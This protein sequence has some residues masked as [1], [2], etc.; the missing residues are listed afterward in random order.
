MLG[1]AAFSG[2][3]FLGL[4]R[5]LAWRGLAVAAFGVV[6]AGWV[7]WAVAFVAGDPVA[8]WRGLGWVALFAVAVLALRLERTHPLRPPAFVGAVWLAAATLA[9]TLAL[10][11]D[12]VAGPAWVGGS[13]GAVFAVGLLLSVQVPTPAASARARAWAVGGLLVAAVL[14]TVASW[15]SDGAADPLPTL[16][17]LNPLGLPTVAVLLGVVAARRALPDRTP[18]LAVLVGALGFGALTVEVLRGAHA[19]GAAPWTAD[20]LYAS[21]TAQAALAVTWTVLALALAVVA[22]RR[23]SRGLWFFGAGV[24]AAVVLKLFLVDLSQAEALVRIGA[25]IAVGA[26]G[27]LIGYQAPLPPRP[28]EAVRSGETPPPPP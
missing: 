18:A 4:G 10:A 16:P 24:F 2:A 23:E 15:G 21:S 25:F 20:G 7:L 1:A 12:E 6:G 17:V 27:L 3:L 5:A 19:L 13:V 14:W 28:A 9:L 11:V 26:I 8:G 22:V